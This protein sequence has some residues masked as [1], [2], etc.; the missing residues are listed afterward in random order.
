[1]KHLKKLALPLI[2]LLLITSC[3][4]DADYA[5][6]I[7]N[8]A[9]VVAKLNVAQILEKANLNAD[10]TLSETLLNG[11]KD[12]DM[13]DKTKEKLESI[14]E[15]PE[16]LGIDIRKP[17]YFY[18]SDN[19]NFGIVGA[20]SDNAMLEDLLSIAS[21]EG[22]CSDIC[23]EEIYSYVTIENEA[24][25]AFDET[26]LVI[27]PLSFD[28]K[29]DNSTLTN[30]INTQFRYGAEK[31]IVSNE[32][33]SKLLTDN[34]D[35]AY[36][37]T[38]KIINQVAEEN[39]NVR[40]MMEMYESLNIK[41]EEIDHITSLN[42]ESGETNL[43]YE[44]IPTSEEAEETL[45]L[46]EDCYSEISG[47]HFDYLK[48]SSVIAIACG[49]NGEGFTKFLYETGILNIINDNIS[50]SEKELVTTVLETLKSVNGDITIGIDELSSETMPKC[51]AIVETKDNS[52]FNM[53]ELCF[54]Q[55]GEFQQISDSQYTLGF[56]N[57]SMTFGVN[58]ADTY[59]VVG[60]TQL[61]EE[62]SPLES[63]EF[64]GKKFCANIY[65]DEL[66]NADIVEDYFQYNQEY[67][68]FAKPIIKKISNVEITANSR[69]AELKIKMK[70]SDT[71]LL[72]E[73]CKVITQFI[74]AMS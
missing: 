12:A 52:L 39:H 71:N 3:T 29:D 64:K 28:E 13:S 50:N 66:I 63:S 59:F 24:V 46:L 43:T 6:L 56:G 44:S 4:N 45:N 9:N 20:V 35:M 53:L 69:K 41:A 61:E 32:S 36:Y 15:N 70:D 40:A 26:R 48:S 55:S 19:E 62:S 60:D 47:I 38:G 2:A 14:I 37:V 51:K 57:N 27:H 7:P 65:I 8:D 22:I 34:R 54:N 58:G 30:N 23:N 11:I 68:L 1:M 5:N 67:K 17:I 73:V 25:I 16:E 31:S 33:F 74:S 49:F 21:S 42:F 10:N 72:T 18:M